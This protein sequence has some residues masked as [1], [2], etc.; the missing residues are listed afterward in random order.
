VAQWVAAGSTGSAII[1]VPT[2]GSP[3]YAVIGAGDQLLEIPSVPTF[4]GCVDEWLDGDPVA[5]DAT[6]SSE[7]GMLNGSI[8]VDRMEG[9][10][11]IVAE[12]TDAPV[13]IATLPGAGD[14][15]VSVP[16]GYYRVSVSAL[17]GYNLNPATAGPWWYTINAPQLRCEL[18]T[19]ATWPT[20]ATGTAERCSDA[21][22]APGTITVGLVD[23]VSYF[24]EVSY[25]LD[26]SSTPMTAAT[27]SAA[28]GTHTIRAA[29]KVPTDGIVGLSSWT[30]V[31]PVSTE[32]CELTTLAFTGATSE[33]WFVVAALVILAGL[34]ALTIVAVR[35]RQTND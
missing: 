33:P 15:T 3:A 9:L 11:Y 2:S 19:E 23:G 29:P 20:N 17:P 35:R 30:L 14:G 32:S 21:G 6:C 1:A 25:F 16:P 26:G 7:G 4:D 34:A 12:V 13:L 18:T 10:Q 24:D 8:W 31:I 27:A 22:T 5:T 28:A